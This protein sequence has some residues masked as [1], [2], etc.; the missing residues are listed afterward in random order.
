M[1]FIRV[2]D[3]IAIVIVLVVVELIRRFG[4][5]QQL[6]VTAEWIDEHSIDRY[7][8][9]LRL[10]DEDFQF[11]RKQPGSSPKWQ[12]NCAF[13]GARSSEVICTT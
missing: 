5:P 1:V 11:L 12:R 2:A 6:P 9:M 3:V 8:P 10:L 4:S 7:R 13:S